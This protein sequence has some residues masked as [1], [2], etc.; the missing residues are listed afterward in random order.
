M[1]TSNAKILSAGLV[2][3]LRQKRGEPRRFL[4]LRAFRHWDFPKGMVEAGEDPF[5]AALR[6]LEEET[7]I[8][9]ACFPWGKSYRET[10]MYGPGKIARYYIGEIDSREV[11]LLPNPSLGHPEHHEFRWLTYHEAKPLLIPRI[12]AVLDWAQEITEQGASHH[13]IS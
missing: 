10:E 8:Q 12:S 1:S 2:P 7:Q 11:K 9:T 5:Q 13:Q 3:V 4:F 6:E